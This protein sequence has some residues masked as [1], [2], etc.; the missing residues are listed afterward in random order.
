MTT[1]YKIS[2]EKFAEA[3]NDTHNYRSVM[4]V[5]L[6]LNI[7]ERT[8]RRHAARIRKDTD[9]QLIDRSEAVM[10][11][12]LVPQDLTVIK[13]REQNKLLQKQIGMMQKST[14]TSD[15]L[16]DVI[17]GLEGHKFDNGPP[18]W[19]LGTEK[20]GNTNGV[21]TLLLSDWHYDEVVNSKQVQGIN[22]FDPEIAEARIN[23]TFATTIDLLMNH[24]TNPNYEGIV[25][26]LGGDMLSGLI[27]EEL[28][29]TNTT[30]ITNA[31]FKLAPLM[32]D[33][34][35]ALQ[36]TFG[37]VFVPCVAGNHGRIYQK[38]RAKNNQVESYE[39]MLYHVLMDRLKH[40]PGIKFNISESA[41]CQWQ[42]YH[43]RYLLTH[44]DQFHGGQGIGGVYMPIQRGFVKKQ[45][46]QTSA[47]KPFDIML[48]GHFHQYIH[49]EQWILNGSLKGYDEFAYQHQFPAEE[50]I[51]ACWI[52]HPELDVT[53]RL[54]IKP[55]GPQKREPAPSLTIWE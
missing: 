9:I 4:S 49:G 28:A 44:G 43:K 48:L 5:G 42:V 36:Q 13:L 14:I 19:L 39:Y 32:V 2:D 41:D 40:I 34:I 52:T 8:V 45:S 18:T 20:S 3:Y 22:E 21:P 12:G 11:D 27:H 29:E 53:T 46:R 50:P 47:G 6:K 26:A 17:H 37:K 10:T 35:T 30:T 54:P 7:G 38:K 16:L 23:R 15:K 33:G 24:N 25:C 1:S 31:I 51:Q 55:A